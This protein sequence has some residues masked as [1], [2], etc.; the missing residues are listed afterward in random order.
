MRSRLPG[1]DRDK[2]V[3]C[4]GGFT[5]FDV[6]FDFDGNAID[7]PTGG[8]TL[9]TECIGWNAFDGKERGIDPIGQARFLWWTTRFEQPGMACK[10]LGQN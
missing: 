4:D 8:D 5:W 2:Q 7:D 9:S 6:Q 1:T 10:S 3:S